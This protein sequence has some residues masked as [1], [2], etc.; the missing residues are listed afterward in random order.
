MICLIKEVSGVNF[1]KYDKKY[2]TFDMYDL[3]I[4]VKLIYI[5]L[6]HMEMTYL[7]RVNNDKSW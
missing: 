3:C 2:L 6:V 1:S 5:I 4:C 7:D